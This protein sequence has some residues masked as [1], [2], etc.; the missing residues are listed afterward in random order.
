MIKK[1][2]VE[3]D[4]PRSQPF[5]AFA[6]QREKWM[7]HD[8]YRAPGKLLLLSWCGVVVLQGLWC[9][10]VVV[11][12]SS[13]VNLRWGDEAATHYSCCLTI[14]RTG[15]NVNVPRPYRVCHNPTAFGREQEPSSSTARVPATP[16]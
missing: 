12:V 3:L 8:M 14:A 7:L 1:A 13:E 11:A 15:R 2:L 4:G 9:F 16:T 6:E 5:Q 10:T